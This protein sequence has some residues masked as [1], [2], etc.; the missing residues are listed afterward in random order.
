MELRQLRYFVAV[1][2]ERNI[3]RAAERLFMTQPPL[4]R[5]IRRLEEELGTDLFIRVPRGMELTDAGRALVADARKVLELTDQ[6]G[7][8]ARLAGEGTIG[9]VDIALFG[10]GIFGVI[11]RLLRAYRVDHPEVEIVLHNMTKDQQLDALIQRHIDLAFNRLVPPTPGLTAEVLLTE[12]LYVAAP[13]AH[14]LTARTAITLTDLE[15]QPLVLFPTGL[16]P[17]FIDRVH[18]LCRG[19]GFTPVVA[20]EV[21]DVVHGIA[22]IAIGEGFALVPESATNL[23]VPGVTYRPLHETPRP[24]VELCAIH[25]DD[26]QSSVLRSL[27]ASMRAGRGLR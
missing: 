25:R 27:L 10:T 21:H 9:R 19:A 13:S 20:A 4:S 23:H 16:R 7:V 12:P 14:P 24:T 6:A 5:Q 3:G 26:D 22:L 2:E 11:P 8:R 1:A 18:D 15:R 17:S